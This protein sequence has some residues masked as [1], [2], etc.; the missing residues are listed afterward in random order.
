VAGSNCFNGLLL[1]RAAGAFRSCRAAAYD[2]VFAFRRPTG[3]TRSF[4]T[5]LAALLGEKSLLKPGE[6][7][8]LTLN[9]G[10]P[11]EQRVAITDAT[12]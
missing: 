4:A 3:I 7:P 1:D 5:N 2:Y 12:S 9:G 10:T 6:Y 8:L 11:D